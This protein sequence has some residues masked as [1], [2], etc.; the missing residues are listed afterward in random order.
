MVHLTI[1]G[2]AQDFVNHSAFVCDG[3]G[4]GRKESSYDGYKIDWSASNLLLACVGG[5]HGGVSLSKGNASRHNGRGVRTQLFPPLCT[6][7]RCGFLLL[8]GEIF[9]LQ[10]E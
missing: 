7:K 10:K 9:K 6:R 8:T 5:A 3:D 2:Q 1:C 4:P